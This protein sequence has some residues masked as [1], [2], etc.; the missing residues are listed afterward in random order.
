MV[1]NYYIGAKFPTAPRAG[2][3]L[4]VAYRGQGQQRPRQSGVDHAHEGATPCQ[5]PALIH[6]AEPLTRASADGGRAARK[7]PACGC[8]GSPAAA[9]LAARLQAGVTAIHAVG[10]RHLDVVVVERRAA[11]GHAAPVLPGGMPQ[12][13]CKVMV[14]AAQKESRARRRLLGARLVARKDML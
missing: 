9:G 3:P 13:D 6:A 12:T 5:F 4:A 1:S 8:A 14:G 10:H 2:H 7:C 11:I